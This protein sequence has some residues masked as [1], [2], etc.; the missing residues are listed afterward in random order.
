MPGVGRTG[1]RTTAEVAVRSA[2][3]PRNDAQ[4]ATLQVRKY[5]ASL[6]PD[7]RSELEK[8]REAIHAG[9]PRAIEGVSYGILI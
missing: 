3:S 6:P 4:R 5:L 2:S 8:L 1:K 9:A 7:A